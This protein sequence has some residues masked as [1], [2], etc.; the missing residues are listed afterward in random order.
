MVH[1]V[2]EHVE[3]NQH[4]RRLLVYL[5][6]QGV[7]EYIVWQVLDN[8]LDWFSLDNG[9]YVSLAPNAG[10]I[11]SQVFPGLWLN[12]KALISGNMAQV[13]L[14]LQQGINSRSSY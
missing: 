9:E 10:I 14:V 7:K 2:I 13:L 3:K 6:V 12:V 5:S 11:K 4:R 8:K 1:F